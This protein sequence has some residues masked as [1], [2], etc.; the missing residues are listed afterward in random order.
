MYEAA[1]ADIDANMA[2][3]AAERIEV[4][5]ITR[6]QAVFF[7]PWRIDVNQS[8][9]GARQFQAGAVQ[10]N[11]IDQ[12]RAVEAGFRGVAA[13][14]VGRSDQADSLEQDVIGRRFGGRKSDL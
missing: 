4:D 2:D 1:F 5:E 3:A 7:H 12:A 8:R 10:E 6:V 9:R 13:I 11:V 14:A